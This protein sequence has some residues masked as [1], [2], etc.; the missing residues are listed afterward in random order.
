MLAMDEDDE[1]VKE[2]EPEP[3]VVDEPF[4]LKSGTG[5]RKAEEEL[6]REAGMD[7]Q[8]GDRPIGD[9]DM[10][11]DPAA[12][13]AARE[14]EER[15]QQRRAEKK[16]AKAAKLASQSASATPSQQE[17]DEEEEPFDYSKAESVM[18][19]KTPKFDGANG[20]KGKKGGKGK[21]PFDPYSKSEDAKGGMRR[22]Q[23]ERAGKSFTFRN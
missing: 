5:K 3:I 10:A 4:T 7:E 1:D 2:E 6:Q 22:S 13:E 11:L 17:D 14:R 16:A 23:S 19:R 21:K 18:N 15:R 12:E 9:Y 8:T 20:A